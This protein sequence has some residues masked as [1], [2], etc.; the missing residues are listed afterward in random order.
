MYGGSVP[1]Y[2]AAQ[3]STGSSLAAFPVYPRM[4]PSKPEAMEWWLA[5][6]NYLNQTD[7]G[8]FER[9]AQPPWLAK[10]TAQSDITGLAEVTLP[11]AGDAQYVGRIL[12]FTR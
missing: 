8:W 2:A 10:Q 12:G 5:V 11:V 1:L 7:H 3:G 9:G 4:H 6:E